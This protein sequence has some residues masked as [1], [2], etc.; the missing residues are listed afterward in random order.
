[1]RRV[2]INESEDSLTI[3]ELI[4]DIQRLGLAYLFEKDTKRALDRFVSLG[5]CD[6]LTRKSLHA[7]ALSFRLLKQHGYQVHQG[8]LQ[9]KLV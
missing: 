6:V 2:I 7:V 9:L 8:M 5:G 1:M 4:D 3:L